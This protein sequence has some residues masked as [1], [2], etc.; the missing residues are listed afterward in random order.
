MLDYQSCLKAVTNATPY[1]GGECM[2][3]QKADTSTVILPGET[4]NEKDTFIEEEL[5]LAALLLLGWN[6]AVFK[7]GLEKIL[8]GGL[9]H[10]NNGELNA[11]LEKATY[12]IDEAYDEYAEDKKVKS[13]LE[14]TMLIGLLIYGSNGVWK[15]I[16]KTRVKMIN[17]FANQVRYWMNNY[18]SR[19]VHPAIL[20]SVTSSVTG[21]AV[22]DYAAAAARAIELGLFDTAPYWRTVANV[23]VSRSHHYGILR[24]AQSRKMRGYKWISVLD[25]RT[26]PYCRSMDGREFWV[27]N[28][29]DFLEQI[30]T[31]D[32]PQAKEFAPW[33]SAKVDTTKLT[34]RELVA[35]GW[36]LPPAHANCRST[37]KAV[38]R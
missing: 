20:S 9:I 11:S 22:T 2:C 3:C 32:G 26:T 12:W 28:G 38:Y 34:E 29:L 17:G 7:T 8:Q 31:M 21:L 10:N 18:F 36:H 33:P 19:I 27:S 25:K 14:K 15:A 13:T 23:Q 5:A 6:T 30:S 35:I 16:G 4:I 1:M 37:V 24:G